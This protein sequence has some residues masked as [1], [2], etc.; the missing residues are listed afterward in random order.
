MSDAA[1]DVWDTA[2]LLPP[3][4][5]ITCGTN[6][7]SR[8]HAS[9]GSPGLH[10]CTFMHPH[11]SRLP[12]RAPLPA[13]SRLSGLGGTGCPPCAACQLASTPRMPHA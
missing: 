1:I 5:G 9:S 12:L 13:P 3:V 11:G 10:A 6:S 7:T 4:D 2:L 8:A